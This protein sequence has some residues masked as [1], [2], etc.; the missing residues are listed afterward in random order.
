M[1]IYLEIENLLVL[2]IGTFPFIALAIFIILALFQSKFEEKN[3]LKYALIG[4]GFMNIFM[5][6]DV[7]MSVPPTM[8]LVSF[9]VYEIL[10]LIAGIIAIV[11]VAIRY[12]REEI[13]D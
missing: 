6:A 4:L 5:I 13:A 8:S 11:I 9:I 1:G 2:V 7:W 12:S 3:L 10:P